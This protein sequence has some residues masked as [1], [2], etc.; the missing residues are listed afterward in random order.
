MQE[1]NRNILLYINGFNVVFVQHKLSKEFK[2]KLMRGQG[3]SSIM[4]KKSR[5]LRATLE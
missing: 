1:Y 3:R 4:I 5:Y 2:D